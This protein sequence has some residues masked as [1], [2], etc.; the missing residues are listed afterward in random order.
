MIDAQ[1]IVTVGVGGIVSIIGTL[2]KLW[3][4]HTAR[5]APRL[6]KKII[7]Y[8]TKLLEMEFS[9]KVGT[10]LGT[11]DD[12]GEYLKKVSEYRAKIV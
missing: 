1:I 12:L 5:S 7:K 8:S 3:K 9:D 10:D 11:L 4:V 2:V 6:K